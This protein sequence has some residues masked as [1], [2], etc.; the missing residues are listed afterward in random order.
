[1]QKNFMMEETWLS[2]HLKIK[3]FQFIMKKTC[4]KLK[5]ILGMKIDYKKFDLKGLIS[6]NERDIN[7]E[8]VKK[9]FLVQDLSIAEKK[10]KKYKNT[11]KI[12]FR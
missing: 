1:M 5:I 6:L 2:M 4:L 7:N 3:Y 12:K 10:L 11:K 8:F 9:P